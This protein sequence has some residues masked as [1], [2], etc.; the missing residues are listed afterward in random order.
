MEKINFTNEKE[1]VLNG[2]NLNQLQ[3]NVENAITDTENKI[4]QAE[5]TVKEYTNEKV[6][7]NYMLV[8]TTVASTLGEATQIKLDTIVSNY[9][10]KLTLSNNE[11]TI[12]SG[13]SKIRVSGNIFVN[14]TSQNGYTWGRIKKNGTF[15]A[16]TI[17]PREAT[18]PYL[19]TPIPPTIEEVTEGDKIILDV[20]CTCGGTLR[21]GRATTWLL[22]EVIE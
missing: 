11:I 6:K 2:T 10:N 21:A 15:F 18:T 1:P 4:T 13:V 22:I 9:G 17:T 16:G 12:G 5:S 20:N 14:D 3:T 7:T 8:T 19:S